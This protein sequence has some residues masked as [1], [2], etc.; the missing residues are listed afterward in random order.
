MSVLDFE[1]KRRRTITAPCINNQFAVLSQTFHQHFLQTSF[2]IYI[3]KCVIVSI[4]IPLIYTILI[5]STRKIK[6]IENLIYI[7]QIRI[8][9]NIYK[10]RWF[11]F[12]CRGRGKGIMREGWS[13]GGIEEIACGQEGGMYNEGNF[14]MRVSKRRPRCPYYRH[15]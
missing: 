6:L 11:Y 9:T 5:Y 14:V 2:R 12:T 8:Y 15:Y 10:Y 4:F 1:M 7:N 3:H 13:T